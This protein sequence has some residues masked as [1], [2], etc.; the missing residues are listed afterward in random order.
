MNILI[1]KQTSLGDVLHASGHIRAIKKHYPDARLVLLTANSSADIYRYN[2]MV[3]QLI[4]I[5]RYGFKNNW[6]KKPAWAFAEMTRVWREVR[7]QHFDLAID[8]QGLAKTVL[9]LYGA[10]ADQK[11]VKGNWWGLKGFRDKS[12]HAIKEMDEVLAIAGIPVDDSAM[13]IYTSESEKCSVDSLLADINPENKPILILSPYTRWK[14]KNWPLTKYIE[15]CESLAG[16]YCLVITGSQDRKEDIQAGLINAGLNQSSRKSVHNLA[17]NISLLEF[18]ELVGR[19]ELMI[20]GD[21]FPMHLAGA[22]DTPVIALF[23]PTDENKVG[24]LGRH[25]RVIRVEGCDVCD[26]SDCSR[27]CLNRLASEDVVQAIE[28]FARSQEN[29]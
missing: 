26:R 20:T 19:A 28:L 18:A 14:S 25:D 16:S 21:S 9:F 11:I 27:L 24:P 1:I 4:L 2:P 29:S 3:D 22:R 6:Y 10:R 17:G 7:Q 5:D 23:G 15:I 12:L 13:A 8:L